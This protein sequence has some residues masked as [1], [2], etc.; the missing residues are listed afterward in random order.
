MTSNDLVGWVIYQIPKIKI[1]ILRA[2]HIQNEVSE[3]LPPPKGQ[4]RKLGAIRLR[5]V[6]TLRSISEGPG[7]SCLLWAEEFQKRA[8]SP[9]TKIAKETPPITISVRLVSCADV[10]QMRIHCRRPGPNDQDKDLG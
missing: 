10:G 5:V 9:Q 6:D 7:L 8:R 2:N 4:Q 1:H 3:D